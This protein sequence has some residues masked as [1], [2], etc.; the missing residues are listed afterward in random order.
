MSSSTKNSFSFGK[1]IQDIGKNS[2]LNLEFRDTTPPPTRMHVVNAY[3]QY[4]VTVRDEAIVKGYPKHPTLEYQ[5]GISLGNHPAHLGDPIRPGNTAHIGPVDPNFLQAGSFTHAKAYPQSVYE[6]PAPGKPLDI[7]VPEG[8]LKITS[9]NYSYPFYTTTSGLPPYDFFKPYGPNL[10]SMQNDLVF[11]ETSYGKGYHPLFTAKKAKHANLQQQIEKDRV[12]NLGF[13][14]GSSKPVPF[15]SSVSGFA[16][17]PEVQTPWEKIGILTQNSEILNLY[18]R[19]IAPLQDLFEYTAQDKNGFIIR[20]RQT[21][22]I[23]NGDSISSIDGKPGVWT[24]HIYINDKYV[25]V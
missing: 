21:K 24:A 25:W 23:E 1:S 18:R 4:P 17:F 7:P 19:P 9:E 6:G 8:T 12:R 3:G 20:L 22:R 5:K 14:F 10:N 16:P 15:I 11:A 13:R 2:H